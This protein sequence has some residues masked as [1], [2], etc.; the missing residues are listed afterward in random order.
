MTI[1]IN[2]D[3]SIKGNDR[4]ETYFSDELNKALS[5]FEDKITRPEMLFQ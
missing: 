1:Q 3:S 4:S 5:R 2:T